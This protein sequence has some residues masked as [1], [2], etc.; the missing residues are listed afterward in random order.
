MHVRSDAGG[1][2]W[3]IA[4]NMSTSGFQLHQGPLYT[5]LLLVDEVNR[6]PPQTP[7]GA[8]GMVEE[9]EVT[10]DGTGYHLSKFFPV[11]A[12]GKMRLIR[13]NIPASRSSA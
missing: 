11:F 1:H 6:M 3:A 10:I 8:A 12:Y 9:R 7:G 4:L 13:R 2:Y 5:D